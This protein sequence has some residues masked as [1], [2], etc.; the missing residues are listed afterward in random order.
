MIIETVVSTVDS[1]N[2]ANFAPM[3]VVF[4]PDG[5]VI[6]PFCTSR[7]YQNLQATGQA[8]V[9]ITDNVLL[10]ARTALGEKDVPYLPARYVRSRVLADACRYYEVV[11]EDLRADGQRAS[12]S[13]RILWQGWIRDFAGFNRAKHAVVEAAILATRTHLFS[14]ELVAQKLAE[15][16]LLVEKTGSHQ[17]K[18]A[19]E[20]IEHYLE[21][22]SGPWGCG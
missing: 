19:M 3:G 13:C 12:V 10:L 6:R 8:V 9:N 15:Y 20:F 2:S 7:T 22:R 11:V 1:G 17:E 16:R 21:R 5:L 4:T 18:S 14:R